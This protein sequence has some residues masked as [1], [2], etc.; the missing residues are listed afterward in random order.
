M[1]ILHMYVYDLKKPHLGIKL[2]NGEIQKYTKITYFKNYDLDRRHVIGCSAFHTEASAKRSLIG[3][4]S[5]VKKSTFL[6]YHQRNYWEACN[7]TLIALT[8]I[9]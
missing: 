2:C 6:Y 7:R 4:L 3:Y 8:K 1:N 5:N 9:K